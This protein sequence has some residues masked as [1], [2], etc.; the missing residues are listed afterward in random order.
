VF[1]LV[2][3]SQDSQYKEKKS[4]D[5][6]LSD[7]LIHGYNSRIYT[8]LVASIGLD[9]LHGQHIFSKHKQGIF[10]IYCQINTYSYK[11]PRKKNIVSLL[12]T[13]KIALVGYL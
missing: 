2:C 9:I 6:T 12:T 4:L 7:Q 13:N 5:G 8:C 11:R 10:L 1:A 3:N